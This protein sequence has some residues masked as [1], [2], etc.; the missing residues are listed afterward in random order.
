MSE[1]HNLIGGIALGL[2]AGAVI[3]SAVALLSAPQPGTQTR[4]MI[5]EKSAALRERASTRMQDT[6]L[7]ADAVL[8]EV[9]AR[10]QEIAG[11]IKRNNGTH[12]SM[13]IIAE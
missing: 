9:K 4:A 8:T 2:L 6:R 7:R 3:G 11:K 12:A 10:S 5:Q 1:K 13:E